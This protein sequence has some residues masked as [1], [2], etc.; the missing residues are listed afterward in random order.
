MKEIL[1]IMTSCNDGYAKYVLPQLASIAKNLQMYEVHFYLFHSR[2][3]PQNIMLIK[4]YCESLQNI[5]F[6][7]IVV[8]DFHLYEQLHPEQTCWTYEMYYSLCCNKYLP[9]TVDRILYIDAGDVY[10]EDEISDYYFCD[11][12]DN[13]LM[14]TCGQAKNKD[15]VFEKEDF[16]DDEYLK[17]ILRGLFNSGSYMINVEKFR[18]ENISMDFYM[19]IIET[20]KQRPNAP[21]WFGDQGL[22]SIAFVGYI[23][24]FMYPQVKNI[25]FMPYNFCLWFFDRNDSLPYKPFIV[26][27]AGAKFK[28][29]EVRSSLKQSQIKFYEKWWEYC[30]ETP[31]YEEFS[32]TADIRTEVLKKISPI[33][34]NYNA[35]EE[36]YKT[37]EE[38]CKALEENHKALEEKYK[39]LEGNHN[40]VVNA[41]LS[42]TQ[43][44]ASIENRKIPIQE[45]YRQMLETNL[46]LAK[47]IASIY[48]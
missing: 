1:N 16:K 40:K 23:K 3:Q 17:R 9:E 15:S 35:L 20:L 22:L 42:T 28:P 43:N 19:Q 44:L 6:H 8:H 47:T 21:K 26:H 5:K 46:S 18:A 12:E 27:F 39:T 4:D 10:I 34:E 48:R 11:F 45:K 14:V 30:S 33:S 41:C 13:Y 37:L 31:V 24:Y 29:W 38:K 7:E 2:V 36:K 32:V 25:Y